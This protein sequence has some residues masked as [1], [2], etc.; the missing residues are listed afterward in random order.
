VT[1]GGSPHTV[2]RPS[3]HP[4]GFL[5]RTPPTLRA[6]PELLPERS[7]PETLRTRKNFPRFD[8]I[9]YVYG[10]P[11]AFAEGRLA[12]DRAGGSR[13]GTHPLAALRFKE[14]K[15]S[16]TTRERDKEYFGRRKNGGHVARFFLT[17]RRDD[18]RART[19]DASVQERTENECRDEDE[20]IGRQPSERRDAGPGAESESP[21]P[22]PKSPA[23]TKSAP[24]M[25]VAGGASKLGSS[26]GR[27]TRR[28][29]RN[30]ITVTP[31]APPRTSKRLGSQAPATSRKP[32]TFAG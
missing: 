27:A 16:T 6:H 30:E 29:N 15:T 32:M 13:F 2:A 3:R 25:R 9:S 21:Q 31:T 19:A 17:Y 22:M 8:F 12:M 23:P 11:L 26:A 1:T 14:H 20:R 7:S 10:H 5:V 24:S 18:S 4:T 28:T